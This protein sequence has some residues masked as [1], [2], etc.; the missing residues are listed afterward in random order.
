[1]KQKLKFIL[2]ALL[3]V[4]VGVYKFVGPSSANGPKPKV[5]GEVYV[6]P[7]EFLVNLADGGFAKVNV[8][9]LLAHAVTP[10]KGA[11]GATPPEGFGD[12]PEEAVVRDIV[13][14]ELT[15]ATSHE[16]TDRKARKKVKRRIL[17]ALRADT[18]VQVRRVL[19]TDVAIQ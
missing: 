15:D 5:D 8:A 17:K 1:V 10:P 3:L 11:E 9:L 13:T 2:P 12:L 19:L 14:D 4:L 6:L 7:K 16:L 18:D